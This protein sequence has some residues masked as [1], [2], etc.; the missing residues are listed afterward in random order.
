M[1][2][3]ASITSALWFISGVGIFLIACN[4]MSTNLVALGSY[5]LKTLFSKASKNKLIG[6]GIGALATASIQSSSATT[7]MV[8]GFVNAGLMTLYEAATVIF[9]ANIGTTV[10]GQLVALGLIDGNIISL[11]VIFASLSGV[12]AFILA[13]AKSKKPKIIGGIVAGF[14]MLFVGLSVMSEAM[15][16][17]AALDKVK[18][19][20]ALFK[21]PVLLVLTGAIL[22][23]AVQSSSVMT[24]M[25]ITSVVAGLISLNQGVY[26]TLGSNIGTCVTALIAGIAGSVNAKRAAFLHL[27]FNVLG[28]LLFMLIGIFVNFGNLLNL[29][30]PGAPHF[31]LAMFHTLFNVITVIAALPLTGVLV[32]LSIK[33]IPGNKGRRGIPVGL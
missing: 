29:M 4:M 25:T 14:G 22:T 15:K 19:F 11:P 1:D 24:S 27:I 33:L 17:F 23:A 5:R 8:I 31:Q 20:L 30:F 16:Y 6:V 26:I 9:G 13:L 2:I 7:V 3:T 12:G 18:S 28:V 10:T 32:K 21:N